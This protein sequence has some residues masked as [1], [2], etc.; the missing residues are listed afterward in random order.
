MLDASPV[1]Q[2]VIVVLMI[3]LIF[4]YPVYKENFYMKINV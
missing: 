3:N 2:V 1:F 4:V